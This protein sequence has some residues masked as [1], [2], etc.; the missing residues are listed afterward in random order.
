MS[1]PAKPTETVRLWDPALRLFHWALAFAVI[2]GWGLGKFGPD[3]MTLHFY[4]GYAVA[5]LLVFRIVWG[6]VGP[7]AARF[8]SFLYGPKT[9]LDYLKHLPEKQP[10]HWPGH[11]PLGALSVFAIL[12]ILAA[13]VATG[14]V[15]D[16]DDY[17][18]VGPLA[19]YVSSAVS[20]KANAW[21]EIISFGVLALVL[22]HIGAILFYKRWKGEDLIRP[23]ITGRKT[24][25][26]R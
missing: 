4:C 10:S 6:L 21:H 16:P 3:I 24:V 20:R 19:K 18:N 17:I 15:S 9:T 1:S 2:L 7:R 25:R 5:G 12:G 26:R 11:N 14:L 13:Q 22:L 8:A 23:M